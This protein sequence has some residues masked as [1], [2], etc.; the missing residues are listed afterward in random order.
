MLKKFTP[1]QLVVLSF[2]A[3]ITTGAILLM[4]PVSSLSQ[5]FTDPITAIFT[6]TSATC[7]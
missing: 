2:L 4:L 5:R 7:V 6:A 1:V 3:V